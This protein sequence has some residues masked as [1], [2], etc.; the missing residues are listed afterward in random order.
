MRKKAE[1][2]AQGIKKTA[3]K[4]LMQESVLYLMIV[5]MPTPEEIEKAK[6]KLEEEKA[7]KKGPSIGQ[8]EER[9]ASG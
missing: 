8:T 5:N 6:K 7:K 1:Q 2:R 9:V 3:T 4:R